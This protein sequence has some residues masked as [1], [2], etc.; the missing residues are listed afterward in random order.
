MS[1]RKRTKKPASST[2]FETHA[3]AKLEGDLSVTKAPEI[4]PV[5]TMVEEP[6]PEPTPEPKPE[7]KKQASSTKPEKV[8]CVPIG[9]QVIVKDK[10]GF[11][12]DAEVVNVDDVTCMTTIRVKGSDA[13]ITMLTAEV[14]ADLQRAPKQKIIR[15][16]FA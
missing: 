1:K 5:E 3:S 9:L 6:K 13:K 12:V 4:D 8:P 14:L 7:P 11:T 15:A 16:E 10:R 2:S